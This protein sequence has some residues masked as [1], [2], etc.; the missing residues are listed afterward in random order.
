MDTKEIVEALKQGLSGEIDAK[1]LFQLLD[2]ARAVKGEVTKLDG[3]DEDREQSKD[4]DS[5]L[6]QLHGRLQVT[7]DIASNPLMSMLKSLPGVAGDLGSV[8]AAQKKNITPLFRDYCEKVVKD[9]GPRLAAGTLSRYKGTIKKY[10]IPAFGDKPISEITVAEVR[11]W[12]TSL[13]ENKGITKQTANVVLDTLQAILSWAVKD[14]IITKNVATKAFV[15]RFEIY[16]DDYVRP[17]AALTEEEAKKIIKSAYKLYPAWGLFIETLFGTGARY[18][19]VAGM[20][21]EDINFDTGVWTVKRQ[22]TRGFKVSRTKGKK[23]R[24]VPLEFDNIEGI[25]VAVSKG[26]KDGYIFM[27]LSKYKR[28]GE[29]IYRFPDNR[30]LGEVWPVILKHAGVDKPCTPHSIRGSRDTWLM[31]R[32]IDPLIISKVTGHSSETLRAT[33]TTVDQEDLTRVRI[34]TGVAAPTSTGK[35][36]GKRQAKQSTPIPPIVAPAAPPPPKKGLTSTPKALAHSV[37]RRK[38]TACAASSD[39]GTA[40]P[41]VTNQYFTNS[42]A[43]VQQT[44]PATPTKA[45]RM[46]TSMV[47]A[48]PRCAAVEGYQPDPPP[49][50]SWSCMTTLPILFEYEDQSPIALLKTLFR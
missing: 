50:D 45:T 4:L 3:S 21:V 26:L 38:D 44:R 42:L 24:T 41:S 8:F 40:H 22:A 43:V 19:E 48:S 10:F 33:Y 47:P 37:F 49:V 34:G 32:G 35:K 30:D 17:K 27:R 2:I 25:K 31:K 9:K 15:D 12:H 11:S 14:E 29:P 46:P 36:Q 28:E 7:S 1:G 6:D 5:I 16:Y 13:P 23:T 39:Q 20:N 18:S